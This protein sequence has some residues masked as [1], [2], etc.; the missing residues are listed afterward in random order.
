[1]CKPRICFARKDPTV[2]RVDWGILVARVITILEFR[3]NTRLARV[4]KL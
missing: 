1:M 4:F 3:P 2:E